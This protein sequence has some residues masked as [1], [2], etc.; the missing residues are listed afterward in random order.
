[1]SLRFLLDENVPPQV[2]DAVSA[3]RPGLEVLS[4]HR[5]QDRALLGQRDQE[6]FAAATA[7]ELTAVT[8]DQRT[9][10]PL[11]ASLAA[12]RKSHCGA[13]F[14]DA[15]TIAPNDIGGIAAAII[16][17]WDQGAACDWT[18]RIAFLRAKP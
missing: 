11:L 4:V 17:L 7:H 14:V 5:W 12:S 2:A 9:I 3:Q 8:Y 10:R 13:V 6:V 16:Q 15:H 18:N 1:M